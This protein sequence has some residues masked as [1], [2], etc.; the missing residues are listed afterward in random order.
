M[1]RHKNVATLVEA[2]AQVIKR[3]VSDNLKLVVGGKTAG[4]VSSGQNEYSNLVKQIAAL[5]I[6]DRVIFTGFIV[7]ED[8]PVLYGGATVFVYPSLY[9]G[10]GFP[11]LEALSCGC[12][13]ICSNAA[14]LP[15]VVGKAGALVDPRAVGE[16]TEK[17]LEVVSL[18][19]DKRRS[20]VERGLKQARKFSW[21]KCA[22]ETATALAHL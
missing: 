19:S 4:D 7:D 21:K 10:F 3:K 13:V 9:E 12:P 22:R 1:G 17:I 18:S 5:G 16:F 14:S 8:L 15:E 6:T 20:V 2:F 11:P